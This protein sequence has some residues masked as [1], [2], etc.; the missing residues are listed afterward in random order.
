MEATYKVIN[1]NDVSVDTNGITIS[2]IYEQFEGNR[3]P[4]LL[5]GITIDGTEYHSAFIAPKVNGTDYEFELYGY[6]WKIVQGDTVTLTAVA[7]G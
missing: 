4:I 7:A 6:T 1:L 3:L 2:G 5:V